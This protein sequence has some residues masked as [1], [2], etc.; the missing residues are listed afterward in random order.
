MTRHSA[1]TGRDVT[2]EGPRGRVWVSGKGSCRDLHAQGQIR[3]DA[4]VLSNAYFECISQL[5]GAMFPLKRPC[6]CATSAAKL[7]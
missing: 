7:S 3:N 4:I 1:A 6:A 2:P 5:F